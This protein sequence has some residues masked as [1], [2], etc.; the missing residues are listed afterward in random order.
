MSDGDRP[1]SSMARV[2]AQLRTNDPSLSNHHL[3]ICPSVPDPIRVEIAEALS[4][5]TVVR[6]IVLQPHDY[7][8]L[9][10]DAMAMYL[11]QS[12]RLLHVKLMG[13]PLTLFELITGT[14][15]GFRRE[16]A[17]CTF[18]KAIGQST[19]VKELNL[20]NLGLESASESFENLL[21]RTKTLRH[22]RVDL[23][24]QEPLKEAATAAIASGFSKNSTLH[25]I[26]LLD[27]QETSL[28]PVLTALRD[29]PVLQKLQ[30]EGFS[31]FT[32]IDAL[33]G[34]KESQLKELIIARFNGS[35]VNLVGFESFMLEMGRNTTI[36]MMVI[37]SVPLS[38]DNIQQLK[39]MLRRNT[40]L[41]DLNLTGDALGSTGLA[42]IA[43]ALYR[44][45]SIQG[46]DV[47]GNGLNDLAAANALRE[48]LRRNKTITRLCMH[49]NFFG[50]NVAVVR[51]IADGFRANTTL[52]ELDLS[53][54]ELDDQGLSILAESLGQQKRGL[55]KL[56]LSVNQIT[57]TGLRALVNN[58]TAAL[59][60]VTHLYLSEN[61]VLGEGATFLAETLRLQTL[62][63]LKGLGALMSALEE[64][65]TLEYLDLE[66][67]TFSV[68]GYLALA[69]SLPN[70]KGLRQMDFSCTTVGSLV[71]P[72]MLEGF[73]KNASL[74]G[75]SIQG[76]E[77]G[78]WSQELSFLLYR[79]KFSRL[80]QDSD[81]DDRE[82]LGLWPRA[83]GSVATRP[84]VL[85]HVLTSKA[86]L[87]RA[88]PGD[89]SNKRKR[90]DSE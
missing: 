39:A 48:L 17:L 81:T 82:S 76:Y 89:D 59:S 6:R 70:I 41:Q 9:S 64:N 43:S 5:N 72:A 42:E 86:G 73:R 28:I 50:R 10:A 65:E 12:K 53:W 31:S 44:N 2:I 45:T 38:I 77:D 23:K 79:N 1:A 71:M 80:L 16:W 87:I 74:Y 15:F 49:H 46:L 25:E 61:S 51:C 26:N 19:S 67:N 88:T 47:S 36:L 68:Q 29:H 55:V 57:C 75:V 37:A 62:P 3:A 52:Q 34:S 21:T 78:K 14:C 69:S 20:M 30:V 60:T 83:L 32:G 54:C 84:D 40:V 7:S 27:W 18:I 58:A 22:L 33:L 63:S 4:Q 85:F 8:K 13:E 35:T 24:R 56:N 11:M 66:E 90:D